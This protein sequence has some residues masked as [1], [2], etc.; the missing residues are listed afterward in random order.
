MAVLWIIKG[1]LLYR[2]LASVKS[3][4]KNIYAWSNVF[5]GN[6]FAN[7]YFKKWH[8]VD[9]MLVISNST[10]GEYLSLFS[11]FICERLT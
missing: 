10:L 6:R 5:V 11:V 4:F 8:T 7:E 2:G 3:A 9:G 1:R